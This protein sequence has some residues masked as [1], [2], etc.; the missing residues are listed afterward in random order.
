MLQSPLAIRSFWPEYASRLLPIFVLVAS[1]SLQSLISAKVWHLLVWY[2]VEAVRHQRR[3]MSARSCFLLCSI[4]SGTTES[5]CAWSPCQPARS[6]LLWRPSVDSA[7]FASQVD[8]FQLFRLSGL[9]SRTKL[10]WAFPWRQCVE[11]QVVAKTGQL[12]EVGCASLGCDARL[13]PLG[14]RWLVYRVGIV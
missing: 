3:L 12:L 14:S 2:R 7:A 13:G 6:S 1:V 5:S 10:Y 9:S 11:L 8:V 4:A